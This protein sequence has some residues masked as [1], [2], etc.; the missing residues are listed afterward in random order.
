M[1]ILGQVIYVRELGT[2]RS[3][4]LLRIDSATDQS[5]MNQVRQNGGELGCVQLGRVFER[6]F[7]SHR[8][9]VSR[10]QKPNDVRAFLPGTAETGRDSQDPTS[11]DCDWMTLRVGGNFQ[12]PGSS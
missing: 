5:G 9:T 12:L 3:T 11:H 6:H 7:K 10:I 4:A 1:Y 2:L 8:G